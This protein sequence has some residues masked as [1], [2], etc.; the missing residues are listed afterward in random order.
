MTRATTVGGVFAAWLALFAFALVVGDRV[1]EK[2]VDP[3]ATVPLPVPASG[4]DAHRGLL[5]GR[6]TADDGTIHEG[7]LRF[8]GDEEA[9]WGNYFNGYKEENPWVAHAPSERLP[10]ERLSMEVFGVGI[11]LEVPADLG[12]PLMAR[13][14]DIARLEARGRDLRVTL[15]SGARFELDRFAADDFADGVRVW[16]GEG[17]FVDLG[18]WDIRSIEFLPTPWLGSSPSPLYGTVR[19]RGGDFTGF[20][21]WDREAC[22]ASDELAG[23][24]VDGD[25]RVPFA[26]IRSIERRSRESSLVTLI[27]GREIVLSGTRAVGPGNRGVYVDDPRYGRVLV[28]WDAFQRVDFSSGGTGPAYGDFP[29]GRP[30]TGSVVTRSGVR[31]TGRLVYDLDES[32]TTETLDAPS[33]GV[34]Y[35][36]PLGLI[37]SIEPFGLGADGDLVGRVTLH[38]GEELMLE[39]AGDL[40]EDNAGMLV[41]LDGRPDPA[42][43]PWIEVEQVSFDRPPPT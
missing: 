42:Y 19:T 38:G 7:R 20:V 5:Y 43:V 11:T 31:L 28:S 3:T 39:R 23:H 27:D 29:P 1:P 34:D 32:Q 10:K 33:H 40:G 24:G 30:L 8:G 36:I 6:V 17:G 4:P 18:E 37:A 21:Q 26:A 15:K 16:D 35:T 41:F 9:L 22:L 12:R 25:L 13:F 2:S 14:G